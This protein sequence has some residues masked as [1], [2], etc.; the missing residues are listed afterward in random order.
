MGDKDWIRGRQKGI[1]ILVTDFKVRAFEALKG[2]VR[3]VSKPTKQLVVRFGVA[4][5]PNADTG[6]P[7][8]AT[9]IFSGLARGVFGLR[10]DDPSLFRK[11]EEPPIGFERY[12]TTWGAFKEA[13]LRNYRYG[14]YWRD[15]IQQAVLGAKKGV[16]RWMRIWCWWP[17]MNNGI[18]WSRRR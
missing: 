7:D 16:P 9:L 13:L 14:A 12:K 4:A 18:V 8:E 3:H 2:R 11:V 17:T 6:L 15:V 5:H 1:D 10:E